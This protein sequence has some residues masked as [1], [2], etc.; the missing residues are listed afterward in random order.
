[1]SWDGKLWNPSLQKQ[2]YVSTLMFK[3]RLNSHW[4]NKISSKK[5]DIS[6][7]L[8]NNMNVIVPKPNDE[9]L[10]KYLYTN[11]LLLEQFSKC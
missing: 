9:S 3:H 1:M 11:V 4:L 10:K 7:W 2:L 8:A 5:L 6:T